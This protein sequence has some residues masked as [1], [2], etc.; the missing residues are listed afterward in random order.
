[1]A[2]KTTPWLK[3]QSVPEGLY[4]DVIQIC[5]LGDETDGFRLLYHFNTLSFKG[6]S[7]R[8]LFVRKWSASMQLDEWLV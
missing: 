5:L 8:F 7:K 6:S 2:A 1:M 4:A 3:E